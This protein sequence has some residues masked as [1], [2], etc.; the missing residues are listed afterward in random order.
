MLGYRGVDRDIT[1][2]KE[3]EARIEHLNRLI[4]SA[5][6]IN[7]L[8]TSEKDRGKLLQHACDVLVRGADYRMV[9]I[10]ATEQGH[11][12]V[13]PVA[14]AGFTEGYLDSVAITWDEA[15]AALDALASLGYLEASTTR[16]SPCCGGSI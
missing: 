5:R 9:W 4:R 14:Q 13:V 3:H 10:G 15:G 16:R 8:L 7:R 11:K 12:R 2:R 6:N 1:Q